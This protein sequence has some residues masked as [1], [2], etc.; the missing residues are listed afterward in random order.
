MKTMLKFANYSAILLAVA[1]GV[2][3][4]D[5]VDYNRAGT[6]GGS[7]TACPESVT[8]LNAELGGMMDA[9]GACHK[10]GQG[11]FNFPVDK[12]ETDRKAFKGKIDAKGSGTAQ[13][14][15]DWAKTH[16]GKT[17]VKDEYVAKIDTW[18]AVEKACPQ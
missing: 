1:C 6:G 7:A 16:T 12:G 11:G 2:T 18:L 14:F 13:G 8:S 10:A 9:C 15:I 4:S 17:A 5:Y 3:K